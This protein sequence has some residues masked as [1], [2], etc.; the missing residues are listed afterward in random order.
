MLVYGVVYD[1]LYI[2]DIMDCKATLLT[3]DTRYCLEHPSL[4]LTVV[5]HPHVTLDKY[6]YFLER[7]SGSW[8]NHSKVN[9]GGNKDCSVRLPYSAKKVLSRI[10]IVCV[11]NFVCQKNINCRGLGTIE[12]SIHSKWCDGDVRERRKEGWMAQ[13]KSIEGDTNRRNR[14]KKR[15]RNH[16]NGGDN[17][18]TGAS[19]HF[20]TPESKCCLIMAWSS[21]RVKIWK[22]F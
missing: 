14:K 7:K 2:Y 15:E 22:H 13:M 4:V 1:N 11:S 10:N 5:P 8:P 19:P 3:T 16:N 9:N 20:L 17:S 12:D 18:E 21:S 6:S